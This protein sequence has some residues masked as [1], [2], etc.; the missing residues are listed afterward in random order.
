MQATPLA[1]FALVILRW[2]F[3]LCPSQPGPQSCHFMLPTIAEMTGMHHHAQL[4]SIEMGSLKIFVP[5]GPEVMILPM[6]AS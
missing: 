3:V 4:F 5:V 2:G 1:L 6:S